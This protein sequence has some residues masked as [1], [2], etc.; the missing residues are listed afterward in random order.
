MGSEGNNQK[1]F[2]V[3]VCE[4][5][6]KWGGVETILK[7]YTEL[8]H[9]EGDKEWRGYSACGGE[10]PTTEDIEKYD[11]FM[12]TGSH[13]SVNDDRE[14]VRKTEQL[15]ASLAKKSPSKRLVGICFGHQLVTKALGGAVGRNPS[16]K[17]VLQTEK[18]NATT[19]DR[20]TNSIS[21]KLFKTGPLDLLESHSECVTELPPNAQSIASSNSCQ[22]EMVLFTDNILG[23]QF[24]PECAAAEFEEKILPSLKSSNLFTEEDVMKTQ[25]S[26]KVPLDSPKVNELIKDFLHQ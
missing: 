22:H 6:E 4:D 18:V 3:L 20:A 11:G 10:I 1:R 5:A 13:Y 15:V 16:G 23:V 9:R 26:F 8:Y 17:F 12:I 19:N 2:A 24:H 25:E 14:W 21:S 7:R